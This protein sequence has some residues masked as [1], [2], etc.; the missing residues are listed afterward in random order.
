MKKMII[1]AMLTTIVVSAKAMTYSE[2]RDEALFLTDKMAYE[3]AL[4]DRQYEDVYKVNLDYLMAI[5]SGSN[6]YGAYW[7]HR[8]TELRYILSAYQ[9]DK[10]MDISYFYRPV[11]W[12][13]N[14]FDFVVYRTYTNRHHY[15]RPH[16][17]AYHA[18]HGPSVKGQINWHSNAPKTPHTG[19]APK[20]HTASTAPNN[21]HSGTLKPSTNNKP[22]TS[23]GSTSFGSGS[24]NRS[25]GSFGSSS[26]NR[27]GGSF[28]SATAK[29]S[30]SNRS[31]S[32]T[33]GGRR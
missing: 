9:Y 4:T 27:S 3:L 32:S 8:N 17:T 21:Y 30:S 1:L 10:Y 23:H 6:L 7:T 16:P 19:P 28:G 33:F 18:Y 22:S 15:Y 2:A 29:V 11:T 24:S 12:Y 14:T 13:N 25:G 20:N 31:S 5:T 26:S